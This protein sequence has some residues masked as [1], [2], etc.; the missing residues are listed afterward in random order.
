MLYREPLSP[1]DHAIVR[2]DMNQ[3]FYI[4]SSMPMDT[5]FYAGQQS[6][7]SAIERLED[8]CH[9]KE[10]PVGFERRWPAGRVVKYQVIKQSTPVSMHLRIV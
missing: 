3:A 5:V 4:A 6:R 10:H 7:P 1:P 9:R 2:C 8:T